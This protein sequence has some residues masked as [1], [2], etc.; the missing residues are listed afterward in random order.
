M[1]EVMNLSS[2][3]EDARRSI[4]R[5][6]YPNKF[7]SDARDFPSLTKVLICGDESPDGPLMIEALTGIQ[8]LPPD[9]PYTPL[10]IEVH[11]RFGVMR[12]LLIDIIPDSNRPAGEQ[13]DLMDAAYFVISHDAD[14]IAATINTVME[15]RETMGADSPSGKASIH[16]VLSITILEPNVPEIT[17]I[18]LP[19]VN[20]EFDELADKYLNDHN[21]IL[22]D[23]VSAAEYV[24][25]D[26]RVAERTA[27]II[28]RGHHTLGLLTDV[29]ALERGSDLE[30]EFLR[31]AK[32][33]YLR[34]TMCWVVFKSNV[35]APWPAINWGMYIH[36]EVAFLQSSVFNEINEEYL[37]LKGLR[38]QLACEA[39]RKIVGRH[40][41]LKRVYTDMVLDVRTKFKL[42]GPRRVD[43]AQCRA[44]LERI[45]RLLSDLTASAN[46][47]NGLEGLFDPALIDHAWID[48]LDFKFQI[49]CLR[50]PILAAKTS[51]ANEM[52]KGLRR[53]IRP[54]LFGY[55]GPPLPPGTRLRHHQTAIA[56]MLLR[57]QAS[58][59]WIE[60]AL[61]RAH[62]CG[63]PPDEGGNPNYCAASELFSNL[64]ENWEDL[65]QRYIENIHRICWCFIHDLLSR[66][67]PRFVK[68]NIMREYITGPLRKRCNGA[69]IVFR[70]ILRAYRTLTE[71]GSWPTERM[72]QEDI[73][74]YVLNE[75]DETIGHFID[76][77]S[78][79]VEAHIMFALEDLFLPLGAEDL[80]DEAVMALAMDTE[81][82]HRQRAALWD[83]KRSLDTVT[84][85]FLFIDDVIAAAAEVDDSDVDSAFESNFDSDVEN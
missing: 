14:E 18:D 1:D 24:N 80:D 17:L 72:N 32:N 43:P 84:R 34:T 44:Y 33:E 10:V 78:N 20:P 53:S 9:K 73:L 41:D 5:V 81:D 82:V 29:Q 25:S 31:L 85:H 38:F 57:W 26:K 60:K 67:A 66:K 4:L 71:D 15:N 8:I 68:E 11:F 50:S 27:S 16:D 47:G 6:M 51:F 46:R 30:A 58:K 76:E 22:L 83:R 23:V 35:T 54:T 12:R 69:L 13:A 21:V 52:A 28:P 65:G 49:M 77:L 3:V 7:T 64:T 48:P 62:G 79:R 55:Y 75:Y 56:P 42:L 45:S 36:H 63:V 70:R 19:R 74:R 59:V 37:G 2:R 61:D 39:S 40:E